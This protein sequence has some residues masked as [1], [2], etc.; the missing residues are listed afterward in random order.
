MDNKVVVL[1]S[2]AAQALANHLVDCQYD[3]GTYEYL[4]EDAKPYFDID[5]VALAEIIQQYWD[6]LP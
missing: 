6:S 2:E 4:H 3:Y 1:P 5:H